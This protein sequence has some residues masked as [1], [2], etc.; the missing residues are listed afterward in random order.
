MLFL[1]RLKLPL[2]CSSFLLLQELSSYRHPHV[3]EFHE[4]ITV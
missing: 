3:V 4:V 2:I 1:P